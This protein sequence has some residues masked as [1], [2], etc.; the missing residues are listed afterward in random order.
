[1]GVN[2]SEWATQQGYE[3]KSLCAPAETVGATHVLIL[4]QDIMHS[5]GGIWV[6]T[7]FY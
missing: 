2:G 7:L 3:K 4:R 1:M 5:L 6:T